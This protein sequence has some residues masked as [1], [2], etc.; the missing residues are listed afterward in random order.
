VVA[1][2][3]ELAD[4]DDDDN[5]ADRQEQVR[6]FCRR[7]V[8]G[9]FRRPLSDEQRRLYVDRQFEEG[10]DEEAAVK[11]VVLLALK[12]P[13]FLYRE[14]GGAGDAFDTASRL[15]FAQW[16][17][18]PDK[19]LLEAAAKNELAAPE[20]ITAQAERMVGDLRAKSKMREFLH[21]WL[22]VD[23]L[24]N[25]SKDGQL[26]PEFDE[27][28]VSDLRTSLDLFLEDVIWSEPSDFRQLLLA[29]SLYLNG[30]LAKFYGADLPADAPFQKVACDPQQRAG[31]LS[32]P[33]LLTGFAYHA[34]SSPIHRGV[35]VARS[36]LGR[37]LK[38]PPVAVAPLGPDLHAGLSTRERVILQT[39]PNMCQSCHAM[40]NP[41]GF[42]LE[43]YDAIG[44]YR[45]EEQGK[46]ID[47]TGSYLTQSGTTAEFAGVRELAAFLA[48][49]H[50]SHGAFAEQLFHQFV[51]Q[52]LRAYGPDQPE[53]LQRSFV[54]SNFHVQRLLVNVAVTAAMAPK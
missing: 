42:P 15:S 30:R 22:K 32:H 25:I 4:L 45:T 20:Q 51:K 26:F 24:D 44:R 7:F 52:P 23:Q 31:V 11:R 27:Q 48:A 38:P 1:R 16:D 5:D 3:D 46:P 39:S 21:Q 34:T 29:D 9:A 50:E 49:S 10:A 17:S 54:E 8:E 43:H 18:I 13:R 28:A 12:S 14:I 19:S 41:L 47:A 6:E 33:L 35:F 2:L 36:L 37:T 53:R 40:I